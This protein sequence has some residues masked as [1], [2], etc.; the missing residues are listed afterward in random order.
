MENLLFIEKYAGDRAAFSNK[1]RAVSSRLGIDPNWLTATMYKESKLNP[2]ARNT[3]FPVQGGYATGLIQFTPD[4]ARSLGTTTAELYNM[5]GVEQMDY[6]EKYF[7]SIGAAGRMR[8]Y[9]DVY[10]AV[11]F[12]AAIGYK[13]TDL[14]QTRKLSA[15]RIAQQNPA[16]DLNRDGVI[17]VAEF[18]EYLVKGFSSKAKKILEGIKQGAVN[19]LLPLA[20]FI[21]LIYAYNLKK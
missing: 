4:T 21:A 1:V 12:P 6:V 18:K 13:D 7:R 17:T 19:N 9:Y 5:G 10:I 8:S 16:I 2:Q 3:A 20:A 15:S 11:F 14:I